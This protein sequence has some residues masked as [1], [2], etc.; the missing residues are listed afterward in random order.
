MP[1]SIIVRANGEAEAAIL[2]G[3]AMRNNKGFL[4]LRKLEAA[5]E[6]AATLANGPNKVML[7]SEGLLL[8]GA[9]PHIYCMPFVMTVLMPYGTLRSVGRRQF[10]K[11]LEEISVFSDPTFIKPT[12]VGIL[13]FCLLL[14]YMN[15]VKPMLLSS[16]VHS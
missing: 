1:Q 8:N 4:Q 11:E 12:A 9:S 16:C 6:I 15:D 3:E 7:D 13:I 2:I 5:R 14:L 10:A